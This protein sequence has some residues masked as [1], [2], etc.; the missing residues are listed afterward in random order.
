MK[1]EKHYGYVCEYDC[2]QYIS[3]VDFYKCQYKI[4]LYG[5]L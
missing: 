1:N 5:H 4:I 2:R 3:Q